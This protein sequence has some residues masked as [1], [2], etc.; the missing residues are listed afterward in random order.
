MVVLI[1]ETRLLARCN[2][3]L[4]C[5]PLD[6]VA[7]RARSAMLILEE[8]VRLGEISS[9]D[10]L[11]CLVESVYKFAGTVQVEGDDDD[12]DDRR[13]DSIEPN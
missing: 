10:S 9:L 13:W 6:A 5:I 3:N 7:F 4:I 2:I 8:L 11:F 12:D 1:R